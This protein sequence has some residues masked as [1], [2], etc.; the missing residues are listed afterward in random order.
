MN[1]VS[2]TLNLRLFQPKVITWYQDTRSGLLQ[3]LSQRE[4]FGSVFYF[5]RPC[6]NIPL[7]PIFQHPNAL[8]KRLQ[9]TFRSMQQTKGLVPGRRIVQKRGRERFPEHARQASLASHTEEFK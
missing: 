4:R 1:S 9:A 2:D 3:P 7:D 5:L 6:S 8:D